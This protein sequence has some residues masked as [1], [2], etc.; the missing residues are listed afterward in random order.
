GQGPYEDYDQDEEEL[1]NTLIDLI[2]NNIDPDSWVAG[3]DQSSI[4]D[5]TPFNRNLVIRQTPKNHLDLGKLLSQ[6]R[7]QRSVLINVETR[8]LQI[9]SDWFEEIGIDLDLY[10]NTNSDLFNRARGIDS[11]ALLSDFFYQNGQLAGQLK[12]P[13]IY[14]GYGNYDGDTGA[15]TYPANTLLTAPTGANT[16]V[17]D[18]S[19]TITYVYPDGMQFGNAIRNTNG[20]SPIGVVQNS[21]GLAET[22]AN[23]AFGSFAGTVLGAAPALGM[24]VSFVDDI[25]V[26]LLVKATQADKR[27]ITLSAPRLTFFNGQGAW[28]SINKQEAYVAGLSAS[29]GDASGA[30]VPQVQVLPTGIVLHLKGAVSADRRYVTLNVYFQKSALDSLTPSA[31]FTGAAGGGFGGG[32]ASGFFG[33]VQ[34]PTISMQEIQVTTSVPDKGTALLGGQRKTQ[35][36][37]TE[38]GVPLF[39][40]MPYINRFFTNRI[41]ATSEDTLLILLRPE[42]IIQ[43]ENEERLFP[44]LTES[45]RAGLPYSN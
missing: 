43:T 22:I 45:L 44:G 24:G 39:S 23:G 26:D 30:F 28:I 27:S 2:R 10:F 5:I 4:G 31:P 38:V 41:T 3:P 17:G 7:E 42:I 12:D 13:I 19:D 37:E 6:L 8:F 9:D 36:Y 21:L 29:T 34:L 32:A 11:N 33:S 1:L 15:F 25:Q 20:W 14:G 16:I 35:E 18:G 40:K